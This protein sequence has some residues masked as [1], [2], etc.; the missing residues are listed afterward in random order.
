MKELAKNIKLII[1]DVDG[2]LT[3]GSIVIGNNGEELKSFSVKDGFAI[4]QAGLCGIKFAII[5]GRSSK[6]V[7]KRA[8]ELKIDEVHQGIKNKV[9]KLKEIMD[10]Y[11]ILE[12]ETAYMGDDVNDLMAMK[13]VGFKGAPFDAVQEIKEAADFISTAP[14]GKGA[15]REFVELILREQGHWKEIVKKYDLGNV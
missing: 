5:T 12:S 3:D 2:T 15:V 14:G 13:M 9:A 11:G 10:K 6:I 7:E 1:L 4:V 8:L